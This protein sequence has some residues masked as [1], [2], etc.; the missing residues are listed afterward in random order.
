MAEKLIEKYKTVQQEYDNASKKYSQ[1]REIIVGEIIDF[2]AKNL[3]NVPNE[4]I[5]IKDSGLGYRLLKNGKLKISIHDEEIGS[6]YGTNKENDFRNFDWTEKSRSKLLIQLLKAYS[7]AVSQKNQTDS[8]I[9][10]SSG[11]EELYLTLFGIHRILHGDSLTGIPPM[12]SDNPF[13]RTLKALY[14]SDFTLTPTEICRITGINR[15]SVGCIIE[16][17]ELIGFVRSTKGKRKLK[18]IRVR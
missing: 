6:R 3:S 17:D 10:D 1:D 16:A 8:L 4:G 11:E 2:L 18:I 15:E 14:L 9:V 12:E 7:E 5:F 13:N